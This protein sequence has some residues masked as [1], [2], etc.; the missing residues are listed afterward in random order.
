MVS[1]LTSLSIAKKATLLIA[2]PVL[3]V[4]VTLFG[5]N[6][7]TKANLFT[8]LERE[9]IVFTRLAKNKLDEFNRVSNISQKKQLIFSESADR[10]NRGVEGLI[11]GTQKQANACVNAVTPL[12]IAL[13]NLVGFGDAIMLCHKS[14]KDTQQALAIIAD[15]KDNRLVDNEEFSSLLSPVIAEV[16]DN[17]NKFSVLIPKI[18]QFVEWLIISSVIIFSVANIFLVVVI[19]NDLRKRMIYMTDSIITICHENDLSARIQHGGSRSDEID[20]VSTSFNQMLKK[21]ELVV[22]ELSSNSH[23]L[24]EVTTTLYQRT[25]VTKE[26]IA[27][28]HTETDCV[29]VAV[30]D[31]ATAIEDISHKTQC[32][33]KSAQDGFDLSSTGKQAVNKATESVDKLALEIKNMSKVVM[34]LNSD[35]TSIGSILDVIREVAEQTNLL[36]LNAA[37]E[38]ARAGEQGRGFAVVADEVRSLASRTQQSTEEINLMI[39]KIQESAKEVGQAMEVNQKA[40]DETIKE[41]NVADNILVTIAETTELIRDMGAQI[42]SATEDQKTVVNEI[43]GNV[44]NIQKA[45][46]STSQAALDINEASEKVSRVTV[47]MGNTV[48]N[49]TIN[50]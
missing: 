46:E 4:L 42:A 26:Q 50:V 44:A 45:S 25:K 38:A 28:Q 33:A 39:K 49:F 12:E 9:H 13:F 16:L 31:M 19:M 48:K 2:V 17:S 30:K 1:M 15:Y 3:V 6:E 41:M 29:A 34:Q 37:I 24:S 43:K 35:T 11:L 20:Q 36:A 47:D 18:V 32:A 23:Y 10:E 14:I 40:S 7:L 8:F 27:T 5:I 21:F 22:N